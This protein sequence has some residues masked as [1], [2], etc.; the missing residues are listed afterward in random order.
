MH[1]T[2][3]H[4]EKTDMKYTKRQITNIKCKHPSLPY[5]H[6]PFDAYHE[7]WKTTKK[8]EENPFN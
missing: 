3:N 4:K 6:I 2:L 8:N 1:S 5:T 7:C